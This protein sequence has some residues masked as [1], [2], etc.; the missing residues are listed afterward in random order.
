[1]K[2]ADRELECLLKVHADLPRQG[3][4]SDAMTAKAISFVPPLK[5]GARIF[6]MG[7]G[8]GRAS[9]VLAQ[10]LKT[11]IVAVD[12]VESF[13]DH[14]SKSAQAAGVSHLLEIRPGSMT[15]INEPEASIDLIW[16]EGAAYCVGF[17][18]ALSVWHRFLK[19]SGVV[20]LTELSWLTD[21][22]AN[23]AVAFWQENYPAMRSKEKN[24]QAAEAIGYRCLQQFVLPSSCWWN[25]YYNPLKANIDRLAPLAS[26]DTV[27]AETI[28]R[29]KKEIS[30]YEC[31]TNDYG[32][33]FYILQK[34]SG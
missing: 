8:P 11:K 34:R 28:R 10:N 29:S 24:L 7:C 17:D 31:H 19:P 20:A 26:D 16:S 32:Y 21:S 6:D 13:L 9:L 25:E 18:H 23:E 1:M 4:G 14:L 15:E 2:Q 22:P 30:L 12:L 27:L 33:V 3:P 5:N